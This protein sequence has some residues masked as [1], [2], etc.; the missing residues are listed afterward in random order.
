MPCLTPPRGRR[1]SR[2]TPR[3]D[4]VAVSRGARMRK[5]RRSPQL[6]MTRRWGVLPTDAEAR[7]SVQARGSLLDDLRRIE[8]TVRE[9]I[10]SSVTANDG[11]ESI[12][13][14]GYAV[15]LVHDLMIGLHRPA[16]NPDECGE[17]ER[18]QLLYGVSSYGEAGTDGAL[19]LKA[20]KTRRL[21][22]GGLA[23]EHVARLMGFS[24]LLAFRCR[25][26]GHR[27]VT[28]WKRCLARW[29]YPVRC[30]ACHRLYSLDTETPRRY[31]GPPVCAVVL[32]C[33][34]L[35]GRTL[36]VV[37]LLYAAA[38]LVLSEVVT[39]AFAPQR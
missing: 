23:P 5:D 13:R 10:E 32:A 6:L 30:R 22:N 14:H 9:T 24:R 37:P 12:R 39:I 27:S 31:W 18:E 26:C 34:W 15:Y 17:A 8:E 36:T 20:T 21:V 25:F 1:R 33:C 2:E 38:I 7:Q 3:R 11:L 28:L 19:H 35:S 29:S 16:R 4:G